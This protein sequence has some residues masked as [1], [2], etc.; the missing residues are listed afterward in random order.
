MNGICNS[1]TPDRLY[2]E[3]NTVVAETEKLLASVADSGNE[4]ANALKANIVQ[5]LATATDRLA[6]IREQSIDQARAAVRSTDEYVHVHPWQSVG[7]AAGVA[8]FAGLVAGMLIAR[9]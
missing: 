5:G 9:R 4:T 6:K 8:A 1:V 2:D 7:V 3:F